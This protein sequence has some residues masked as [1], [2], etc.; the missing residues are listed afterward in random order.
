MISTFAQISVEDLQK[1]S[2]KLEKISKYYEYPDCK[3]VEFVPEI[4]MMKIVFI[5]RIAEFVQQF[6]I[7]KVANNTDTSN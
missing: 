2:I 3:D 4:L 7:Q 1:F 5:M 6:Q